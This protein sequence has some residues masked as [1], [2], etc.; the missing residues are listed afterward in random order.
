MIG[1]LYGLYISPEKGMEQCA[2]D[3][4][5]QLTAL[6]ESGVNY[7]GFA[8]P[9]FDSLL[10]S[11]WTEQY[12]VPF[13]THTLLWDGD[14]RLEDSSA[15]KLGFDYR[16]ILGFLRSGLYRP[17]EGEILV[18]GFELLIAGATMP[19]TIR[20][21][22]RKFCSFCEHIGRM[23]GVKVLGV[24]GGYAVI[25]LENVDILPEIENIYNAKTGGICRVLRPGAAELEEQ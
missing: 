13:G 21:F 23:N 1:E 18:G 24:T 20:E 8:Y 12:G 3:C 6:F 22:S 14:G 16:D 15:R 7:D 9:Y 19:W 17:A 2:R 5:Q 4:R 10:M 11:C 25:T